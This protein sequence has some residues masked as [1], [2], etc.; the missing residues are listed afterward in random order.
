MD[1]FLFILHSSPSIIWVLIYVDDILIIG[2]NKRLIDKFIH[3][4]DTNF[5]L[6]DLSSL[7]YFLGIEVHRSATGMQ[8]S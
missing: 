6:K 1:S 2:N 4:L 5:F 8:L 3:K 7:N